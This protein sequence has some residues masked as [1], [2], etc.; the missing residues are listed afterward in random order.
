[1][2]KSRVIICAIGILLAALI[3]GTYMN[4]V[5]TVEGTSTGNPLQSPPSSIPDLSNSIC[6]IYYRCFALDN[7]ACEAS[8]STAAN[9]TPGLGLN[10]A[11]YP[12]LASV[13]D[14][15]TNGVLNISNDKLTMCLSNI[16]NLSCSSQLVVSAYNVSSPTD[17]SSAY[18][19]LQSSSACSEIYH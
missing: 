10:S 11:A 8:L 9:F 5:R 17:L 12:N 6:Q 13:N 14:A 1:V 15:V 3:S 19:M 18:H 7:S 2:K 16:I 4:C